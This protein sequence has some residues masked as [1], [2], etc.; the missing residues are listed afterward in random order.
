PAARARGDSLMARRMLIGA[1]AAFL[2]TAP[3]AA[4]AQLAKSHRIGFLG[5]GSSTTGASQYEAFQ[6]NLRELGWIEGQNVTIENRWV[7]G[8]PDR[9]P[10]LVAELVQAKV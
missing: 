7:E 6:R 10:A 3:R 9:L 5:N 8:N 4:T 1:V 2:G